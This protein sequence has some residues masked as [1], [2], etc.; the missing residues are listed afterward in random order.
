M[1]HGLIGPLSIGIV[2]FYVVLM[3]VVMGASMGYEAESVDD[4]S[5]EYNGTHIITAEDAVNVTLDLDEQQNESTYATPIHRELGEAMDEYVGMDGFATNEQIERVVH[6]Y[7][8]RLYD[9]LLDVT[10]H[11][12][13]YSAT[14][15]YYVSFVVPERVVSI[16]LNGI[17]LVPLLA[18]AYIPIELIRRH[19]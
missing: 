19:L 11:V 17:A 10:V 9:G 4:T 8:E 3:G 15:F 2:V 14:T 1:N 5:V 6:E 18:L 12:I 13:D 7:T 16:V